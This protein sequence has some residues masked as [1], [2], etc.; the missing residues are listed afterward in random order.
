MCAVQSAI[1][2]LA[3]GVFT[4]PHAASATSG[5]SSGGHGGVI[6]CGLDSFD[7][8]PAFAALP[9][10][11]KLSRIVRRKARL[12]ATFDES[13]RKPHEAL[14]GFVGVPG[15]HH[16]PATIHFGPPSIPTTCRLRC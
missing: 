14:V 10:P 1:L 5:G 15:G 2:V 9:E 12:K 11:W 8:S 6:E 13:D 3:L 4:T 16:P 7:A